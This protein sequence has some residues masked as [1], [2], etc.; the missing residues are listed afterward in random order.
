V[1]VIFSEKVL[2]SDAENI[3]NYSITK[4]ITIKSAVLASNGTDVTLTTS[5]HQNNNSYTITVNNVK[6][7][8]GN[9]ISPNANSFT[10]TY[11]YY[12]LT[13]SASNSTLTNGAATTQKQGSI[14][15]SV[16]Y[17]T[18]SSSEIKFNSDIPENA[19]WY[20]WGRFF[21]EGNDSTAYFNLQVDNGSEMPFGNYLKNNWLWDG[22][23]S[24]AS[25]KFAKLNLNILDAGNHTFTIYGVDAANTNAFLDI[26]LLTND[27]DY[28]PSDSDFSVT[29]AENNFLRPEKFELLQNFPNPFNPTTLIKYAIAATSEVVIKV[30]DILGKEIATL[31]NEVKSPGVYQTQFNGNNLPS[32]IY[33]YTISAGKFSEAKKMV[34][35]K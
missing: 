19:E 25:N 29:N 2:K 28:I 31:V 20:A 3:S 12:R 18:N 7:L 16:A 14:S 35:I 27:A 15:N 9:L 10:Y 13:L 22:D 23:G 6:D 8:S 24:D 33:I 5:A 17:T 34:L 30:Y 4:G 11:K 32:G 21:Y 26:L 1:K